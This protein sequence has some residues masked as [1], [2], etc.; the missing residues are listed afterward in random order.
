MEICFTKTRV[1]A[2]ENLGIIIVV[3]VILPSLAAIQ[4]RRFTS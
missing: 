1:V 2:P 3:S 4:P